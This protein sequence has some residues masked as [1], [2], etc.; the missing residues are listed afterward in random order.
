MSRAQ[1][2]LHAIAA[3]FGNRAR[4][5]SS[6]AGEVAV[7]VAPADLL[8]VCRELRDAPDLAFEQLIDLSGID[9][10][11]YGRDEW[12]TVDATARGF[13]RGVERGPR[14]EAQ[15]SENRFAVSYQLLSVSRNARLRLRCFCPAGEPPLIDSVAEIWPA[16]NWFE[17]EAFDLYGI[18]FRGH[19]DLRRILTDYGFI[20]HPFRK[21]FPLSGYVEVRYDPARGR[22][23][24]EPV[25]IEPRVT[26]PKV[27][28]K[29]R[30][31]GA[32][33]HA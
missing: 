30:T 16:A 14:N 17:R 25:S 19:P 23:V 4:P 18:L 7:D 2:T 8:A 33:G 22:V 11:D 32:G 3:R 26:V 31:P 28:R 9:Y 21:D 6:L 29:E 10:L 13:S 27:I 15:A 1:A 5:A 24:Q 12:T 20:G